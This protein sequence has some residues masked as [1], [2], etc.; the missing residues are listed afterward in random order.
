VY[1]TPFEKG[2]RRATKLY[3][4]DAGLK[5]G[6]CYIADGAHPDFLPEERAEDGAYDN[7]KL[8]NHHRVVET[9]GGPITLW[10][11]TR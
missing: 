8:T 6:S 7:Y 5:R 11:S 4:N 10:W 2:A 3:M 9:S 1:D